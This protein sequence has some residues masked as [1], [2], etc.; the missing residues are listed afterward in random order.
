MGVPL[1]E[2]KRE[3]A[4]KSNLEIYA[5]ATNI[6]TS[7]LSMIRERSPEKAQ[8]TFSSLAM[9]YR[10]AKKT[11]KGLSKI[12][13]KMTDHI[14]VNSGAM[15]QSPRNKNSVLFVNM[16]S[17]NED[18]LKNLRLISYL[19]ENHF[20]LVSNALALL[21]GELNVQSF[22]VTFP[23]KFRTKENYLN[24]I[25]H[26]DGVLRVKEYLKYNSKR[27]AEDL[28][29]FSEILKEIGIESI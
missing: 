26:K 15:I 29:N 12:Q 3:I 21:G 11:G 19:C 20:F 14:F 6:D 9:H 24:G 28:K 1:P 7:F 23:K 22:Q 5:E 27:C 18:G 16:M 4:M 8:K 13:Q 17:L 25:S 2:N 10:K